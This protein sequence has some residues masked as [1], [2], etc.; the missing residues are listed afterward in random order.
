M[1][2]T[3]AE[4]KRL[5]EELMRADTESD[6]VSILEQKG[7]WDDET[8][9]RDYG[10]TEDNISTI[11]GQQSRA[12]YALV[13]KITNSIDATLINKCF[14]SGMKPQSPDAPKTIRDAVARYYDESGKGYI[15]DW[16]KGQRDKVSRTITLATT[17][18]SPDVQRKEGVNRILSPSISIADCGEG[19]TPD[20]MPNTILSI[21]R[22]N[23]KNIAFVQ[24][25]YNQ[26]GTGVLEFCGRKKLQFAMSR[27]NPA[28]LDPNHSADD[29]LWSFTIVRREAP[30][31]NEKRFR[32]TYLAPVQ[33]AGTLGGLLR[34]SAD[35]MPIFPE[36]KDAYARPSE[37]G[38]L[39]KLYEFRYPAHG[40]ILRHPGLLYRLD[41]LL[42][43]MP[44]PIRLYECRKGF[45]GKPGSYHT[46]IA[47]VRVRLDQDLERDPTDEKKVLESGFPDHVPFRV[48][49]D[50]DQFEDLTATIFLFKK[51]QHKAYKQNQGLLYTYNGQVH[52]QF[53]KRFFRTKDVGLDFID[54]SILVFLDLSKLSQPAKADIIMTSRD[55]SR[56]S[57]FHREVQIR[58]KE[59]LKEHPRLREVRNERQEAAQKDR[60]ADSKPLENVLR[61]II[62]R[63]PTL[64]TLFSPGQRLS[65][66]FKKKK[67][68]SKKKIFDEKLHPTYF[69]LKGQRDDKIMHK[70]AHLGQRFRIQFETDAEREYFRRRENPGQ[71]ELFF[72]SEGELQPVLE[73]TG[74]YIFNGIANVNIALPEGCIIGDEI[75][76]V[77]TVTDDTLVEFVNE[78]VVDVKPEQQVTTGNKK[79]SR[80]QPPSDDA[81]GDRTVPTGIS[82]PEPLHL[83]EKDWGDYDFNQFS[84]L[85]VSQKGTNEKTKQTEYM[86]FVNM[87][88]EYLKHELKGSKEDA[89]I[90]KAQFSTGMT[91]IGLALLNQQQNTGKSIDDEEN[92]GE[93]DVYDTIERVSTALAPFLIPLVRE[94][95]RDDF[96]DYAIDEGSDLEDTLE[97]AA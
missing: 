19:Q 77:A 89:A 24:G 31:T 64:S 22:G 86:Y 29:L 72:V 42:P 91:V 18:I 16:T 66:A 59:I 49:Y 37:W 55:R 13:E 21:H 1:N 82:L 97:D 17:G 61:N 33:R 68:K 7:L 11:G 28:I 4:I 70:T 36:T 14:L 32:Y 34:F 88:N 54:K 96:A 92:V 62:T 2:M 38:T 26:G 76:Y 67:V 73:Y 53:D 10:D 57:D 41:M 93:S 30:K 79:R 75:R 84:A 15:Q 46:P 3:N 52:S 12:E 40:H 78:L 27:R 35:S 44:L 8:L 87:D 56:D 74:P 60:I 47:G 81:G 63:S 69:R 95:G 51:D 48:K 71:F 85:R 50:D 25:E 9:W 23:K 65:S 5:C 43:E 39:I 94:L 90:L 45:G 58:L 80:I 83:Y 6:V 20:E